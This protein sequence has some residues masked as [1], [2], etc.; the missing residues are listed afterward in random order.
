MKKVVLLHFVLWGKMTEFGGVY[1]FANGY[2][3][4]V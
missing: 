1:S 4:G 3:F 2:S